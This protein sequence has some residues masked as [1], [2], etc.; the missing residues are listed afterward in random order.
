MAVEER[1]TLV[2]T[3]VLEP[4]VVL[5]GQLLVQQELVVLLLEQVLPS[6]P[7]LLG[8]LPP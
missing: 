1:P 6:T 7:S 2:L 5:Q 8:H 3:V 4:M